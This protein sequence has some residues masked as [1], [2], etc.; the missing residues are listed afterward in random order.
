MDAVNDDDDRVRRE[1][2]ARNLDGRVGLAIN[3]LHSLR[4]I[5]AHGI[6]H[7]NDDLDRSGLRPPGKPLHQHSTDL[8]RL[9]IE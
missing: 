2:G 5:G 4:R 3:E 1:V 8:S 9:A 6:A 7:K